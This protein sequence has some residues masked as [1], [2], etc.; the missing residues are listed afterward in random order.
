MREGES[1][2]RTAVQEE[3]DGKLGMLVTRSMSH[4]AVKCNLERR[5][6]LNE[7]PSTRLLQASVAS[8]DETRSESFEVTCT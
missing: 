3:S 5:S 8:N 2:W 1:K 6:T 4:L 7:L